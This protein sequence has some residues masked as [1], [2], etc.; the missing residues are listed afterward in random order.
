MLFF[1][2][3][4]TSLGIFLLKY[5]SV[6]FLLQFHG[7]V[8]P[9]LTHLYSGFPGS[10]VRKWP[11]WRSELDK[12][13][14]KRKVW[15]RAGQARPLFSQQTFFISH[16][17]LTTMVMMM[18]MILMWCDDDDDDGGVDRGLAK[19]LLLF[20]RQTFSNSPFHTTLDKILKEKNISVKI[21]VEPKLDID[22]NHSLICHKSWDCVNLCFQFHY[23]FC[24]WAWGGWILL[25]LT[26]L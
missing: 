3:I 10:Q 1:F 2:L 13:R 8:P 17:E 24:F 20:S 11:V 9:L 19:L 7:F 12:G 22:I 6:L 21:S 15:W 16:F 5:K 26:N 23:A 18:I 4:C 14:I 25:P